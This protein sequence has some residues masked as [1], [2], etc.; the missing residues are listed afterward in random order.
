MA[1]E[2]LPKVTNANV[3]PRS[4]VGGA[5]NNAL[6]TVQ[7]HNKVVD[8]VNLLYD[9]Q[10]AGAMIIVEVKAATAAS[11]TTDF[12]NLKAGDIVVLIS[13]VETVASRY[14]ISAAADGTSDITPAVGEL[15]I[16]LRSV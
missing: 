5:L 9:N 3:G 15:I 12:A 1:I 16:I 4:N 13:T 7:D 2:K 6:V 10:A 8:A 11:A 14:D